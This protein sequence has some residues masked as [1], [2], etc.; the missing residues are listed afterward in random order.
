MTAGTA[1]TPWTGGEC[2]DRRCRELGPIVR[3]REP[4]PAML[5]QRGLRVSE[6]KPC[7]CV[8][9]ETNGLFG[10]LEREERR[11]KRVVGRRVEGNGSPP[12]CLDVFKISKGEGCN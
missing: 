5:G 3:G 9:C 8:R 6:T 11:G 10:S 7:D 12:P 4:G 1:V 2:L